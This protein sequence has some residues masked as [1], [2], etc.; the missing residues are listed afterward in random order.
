[1]CHISP[2]KW[3]K[4]FVIVPSKS[5]SLSFKKSHSSIP[6]GRAA[7]ASSYRA[8][9]VD[10]ILSQGS[11]ERSLVGKIATRQS[12]G[13]WP[14]GVVCKSMSHSRLS[15]RRHRKAWGTEILL[16]SGSIF[17]L[18]NLNPRVLALFSRRSKCSARF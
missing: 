17:I 12:D 5:S 3:R 6:W 18:S 9:R 8:R 7:R 13:F 15:A 2:S 16:R 11:S 10:F 14:I 1:M 4:T